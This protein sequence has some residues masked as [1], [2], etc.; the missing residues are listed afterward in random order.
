MN[1]I[2]LYR[3]YRPKF[4]DDIVGQEFVKVSFKNTITNNSVAHAYLFYGTRGSGKT[5][6]ARIIAKTLN[7]VKKEGYNPCNFCK[8]CEEFN[9]NRMIDCL[10]I[11]AASNNG[12]DEIRSLKENIKLLPTAGEY[13]IYIIDEVHMLTQS[14]FNAL[15]KTLEEP[16]KHAVFILA[17]TDMHKIPPTVLSRCQ[18]FIFSN[19][20]E[21]EIIYNL[22]IISKKEKVI[23]DEQSF[24]KIAKLAKGSIRD[25]LSIFEQLISFSDGKIDTDVINKV[26]LLPTF[27]DVLYLFEK[28]FTFKISELIEKL[29]ELENKGVDFS[30]LLNDL[31]IICKE[32]LEFKITGSEH[33]LKN[34]SLIN[35]N[36]LNDF[37]NSENIYLLFELINK[38]LNNMN[39]NGNIK[40]Y[41]E[42]ALLKFIDLM[43]TKNAKLDT[44]TD[45]K[46]KLEIPN[47]PKENNTLKTFKTKSVNEEKKIL[48]VKTNNEISET[49]T[50][51]LNKTNSNEYIKNKYSQKILINTLLEPVKETRIK[52]ETIIKE[53]FSDFEWIKNIK[54]RS[55]NK[56][57][58]LITTSNDETHKVF[59]EKIMDIKTKDKI[60]NR[61][62]SKI[63]FVV[64]PDFDLMKLKNDYLFLFQNKILPKYEEL[65][66]EMEYNK[67]NN[68]NIKNK[69]SNFLSGEDI[70]SNYKVRN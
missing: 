58:V 42:I 23:C 44:I 35:I 8:N 39:D 36:N 47:V 67:L 70:F 66:I 13:K 59:Y 31:L 11:D 68:D 5:T 37:I 28:I 17:T 4:L 55:A 40:I 52:I 57:S 60:F 22:K 30:Q 14:A 25:S 51:K 24:Q 32:V 43:K 41:V 15:L 62:E 1:N 46:N 19:L 20:K 29:N 7:C 49:K 53:L 18:N 64:I 48:N 9:E 26:F 6:V 21:S 12:V 33:F 63:L 45:N 2:S 10:E 56:T 61:L 16:P 54:V 50:F 65:D 34:V 69:S 38:S 27:D 3:K